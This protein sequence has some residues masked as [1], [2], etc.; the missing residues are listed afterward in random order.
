MNWNCS[1]NEHGQCDAAVPGDDTPFTDALMSYG[2][3]P[4]V[5]S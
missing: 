4:M 2:E 1:A 3:G 5:G